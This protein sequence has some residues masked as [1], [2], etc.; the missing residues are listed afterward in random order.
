MCVCLCVS[1]RCECVCLRVSVCDHILMEA[2]AESELPMKMS[3][4]CCGVRTGTCAFNI[5]SSMQAQRGTATEL[6]V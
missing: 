3:A 4:C 2:G 1:V 5:G 6:S